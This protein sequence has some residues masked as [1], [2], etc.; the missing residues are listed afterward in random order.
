MKKRIIKQ[1]ISDA[2]GVGGAMNYRQDLPLSYIIDS[3]IKNDNDK[4]KKYVSAVD[5]IILDIKALFPCID[6]T[7]I[8]LSW[9]A[10]EIHAQIL[11]MLEAQPIITL[12]QVP[13]IVK[14]GKS[15]NEA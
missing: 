6:M 3:K 4:F 9:T 14:K 11:R 7:G 2:L 1:I 13:R 8:D 15:K 12:E 5:R 10:A